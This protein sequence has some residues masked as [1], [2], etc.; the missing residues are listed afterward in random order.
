MR[1]F[2]IAGLI[3][4]V[5][6]VIGVGSAAADSTLTYPDTSR[7]QAINLGG[8][9]HAFVFFDI[10]GDNDIFVHP[11]DFSA[12]LLFVSL[13]QTFNGFGIWLDFEGF[14]SGFM[15]FGVYTCTGVQTSCGFGNPA[16]RRGTFFL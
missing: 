7:S 16:I 14:N 1:K 5:S 6:V 9:Q 13:S 11:V 4:A 2:L 15:Q 8:G 12:N 10:P 3:V